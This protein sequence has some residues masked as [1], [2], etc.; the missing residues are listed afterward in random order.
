VRVAAMSNPLTWRAGQ[1]AIHAQT[2]SLSTSSGCAALTAQ[3]ATPRSPVSELLA[4]FEPVT[5]P[6]TGLRLVASPSRIELV[7]T[8]FL[9]AVAA[10]PA[11]I[12]EHSGRSRLRPF[13]KAFRASSANALA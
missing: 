13:P 1:V 3:Q 9:G 12:P 11:N 6:F 4:T 5:T 7:V 2:S 10:Y 8:E